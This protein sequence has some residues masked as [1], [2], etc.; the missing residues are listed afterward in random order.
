MKRWLRAQWRILIRVGLNLGTAV[1]LSLSLG[2]LAVARP[3]ATGENQAPYTPAKPNIAVSRK[4]PTPQ[5][6]ASPT[7][8]WDRFRRARQ[9]E[10]LLSSTIDNDH[11]DAGIETAGETVS[12]GAKTYT[13]VFAVHAVYSSD[14]FHLTLPAGATRTQTLFAATTRPPNGSCLEVGTSYTTETDTTGTATNPTKAALYVFDF[15]KPNHPDWGL[16]PFPVGGKPPM[17]VNADF[18]KTYAGGTIQ[19]VPAYTVMIFTKD[20]PLSSESVWYAQ[21]YNYTTKDWDTLYQSK[22]LFD[23]DP[24]GWSI[25]ETWFQQGQCSE[26]LPVLGADQLAYYNSATGKWDPILPQMTNLKNYVS[27]GGSQN[28]NCFTEDHT[29]PASYT[30]ESVPP[31]YSGWKVVS[32]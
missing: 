24:R 10:Q 11:E 30:I 21:L 13:G 32:R 17:Y 26:S 20:L 7:S 25:F 1:L 29:G 12:S 23:L 28:N 16:A 31:G 15:C 27:H 18:V 14:A 5:P 22:G 4:S 9:P 19:N 2:G 3:Q 8:D 6:A